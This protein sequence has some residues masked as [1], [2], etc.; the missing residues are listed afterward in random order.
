MRRRSSALPHFDQN[1]DAAIRCGER[2]LTG[3][4]FG[5]PRRWDRSPALPIVGLEKFEFQFA[6]F[7]SDW[8]SEDDAVRGI[9]EG[10]RV[11]E[12][13][14]ACVLELK[15][16]VLAGVGGV[17]DAG[18]IAGTGGHQESL[19]GGECNDSAK[20]EGCSLRNLGRRPVTA[21]VSRPEISSMRAAGPGN[22]PRYN[23]D[24]A[25][26]FGC[27]RHLKLRRLSEG[28]DNEREHEQRRRYGEL[29]QNT[30]QVH[31]SQCRLSYA[32]NILRFGQDE[33]GLAP[34]RLLT[35][36]WILSA[37]N[38]LAVKSPNEAAFPM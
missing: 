7:I 5:Q 20:V 34:E 32:R 28:G 31:V 11:E 23:A 18:L 36:S 33:N 12:A 29:S 2:A 30:R 19:I 16:P 13:L 10:Y 15:L 25:E 6:S 38:H 21:T 26:I 35:A 9:P 27:M 3:K 37:P 22:L 14:G 4:S 17:I 1:C 24:A 8:I